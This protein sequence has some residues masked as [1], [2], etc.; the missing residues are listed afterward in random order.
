MSRDLKAASAAAKAAKSF[1]LYYYY[2]YSYFY[3]PERGKVAAWFCNTNNNSSNSQFTE[4]SGLINL[5]FVGWA[6]VDWPPPRELF[7]FGID[8]IQF[9]LVV[10]RRRCCFCS[11]AAAKNGHVF[12]GH[13]HALHL[14]WSG[15]AWRGPARKKDKHSV[16]QRI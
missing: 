13:S 6:G 8:S 5:L 10:C 3:R 4:A 14:S 15:V 1:V 11:T 7:W 2:Y 16:K 9:E 12:P